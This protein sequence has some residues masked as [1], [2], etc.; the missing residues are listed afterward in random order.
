[1]K[2]SL[3]SKELLEIMQSGSMGQGVKEK[4][5]GSLL[6]VVNSQEM[7]DTIQQR[8]TSHIQTVLKDACKVTNSWNKT[9]LTGWLA[10]PILAAVKDAIKGMDITAYI[11]SQ[12]KTEIER[13]VAGA[14][15]ET[16]KGIIT[17]DFLQAIMDRALK[18]DFDAM[19]RKHV[20]EAMRR[21]INT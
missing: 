8:V 5:T 9:Q 10:E 17:E 16:A 13:Q 2:L 19:V 18:V 15:K 11:D 12:V 6:A 21:M 20:T 4:L 1:M 7:K 3:N 14:I